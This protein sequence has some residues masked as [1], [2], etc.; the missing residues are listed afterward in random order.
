M[1]G[2]FVALLIA[3]CFAYIS[4]DFLFLTGAFC[5]TKGSLSVCFF[6]DKAWDAENY[7]SVITGFYSTIITVLI[8][9]LGGVAA[10]AFFAVRGSA[11]QR[12]EEDIEKEIGQY[13]ES[14]GDV[15][16]IV[17]KCSAG[18]AG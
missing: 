10:F 3:A 1:I 16:S 2:A 15:P 9:L 5:Q 11:L 18:A 4:F 13:F 7:L 14:E 12:A 8:A 6:D 17:E